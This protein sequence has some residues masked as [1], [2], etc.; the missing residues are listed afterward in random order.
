MKLQANLTVDGIKQLNNEIEKYKNDIL[1]KMELFT[2]RLAEKGVEVAKLKIAEYDAI[3][4]S[5]LLN[6]IRYENRESEKYCATFVV[7]TDSDHAM[8][9]EFGTGQRGLDS[10]YPYPLPDGVSWEYATGK[11]IR[12]NPKTGRYYWFYPGKDGKWHYTEGLPAR[13]FMFETTQELLNDASEIAR[14]IFE[15]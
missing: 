7:I 9:V 1:T 14:E 11:T 5:E 15:G 8:F 4:T 13:P 12:Q 3:F 6:S 2:K 10:S